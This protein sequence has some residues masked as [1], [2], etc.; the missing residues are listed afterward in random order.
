MAR[1]E[2]AIRHALVA[3]GYLAKTE[4]GNLKHAHARLTHQDNIFNMYYGKAVGA[5]IESMEDKSCPIEVG[6]AACL[7]FVCIEFMRGNFIVAFTHLQSGLKIIS[8]LPY[9]LSSG[10]LPRSMR[11]LPK[12]PRSPT[13]KQIKFAGS[14]G[15]LDDTLIP[16]FMRNITPAMLFGTRVEEIF[17]IPI[18]D[19]QSY[20]FPFSTFYELQR[21]SFQLRNASA[22][23]ARTMA[24]KIFIKV[25]LRPEDFQARSQLLDAHQSWL[26]A[27]ERL[28]QAKCLSGE[29]IVMAASLK[30]GYYSTYILI[31]CAMDLRQC[32]FDAHL[33]YFKA[34][35]HNARIVLESMDLPIVLPP[36]SGGRQSSSKRLSGTLSR[37]STSTRTRPPGRVSLSTMRSIHA[38]ISGAHF[39]FE[40]SVIP[41]LHFV[42]TRCRC[43]TTRR[44]AVALLETNP[45]REGL[46]DVETHIAVAKRV[47]EIEETTLDPET[48]W[49]TEASRLWCSVHDGKGYSDGKILVTFAFAQW[50]QERSPRPDD[51]R[52]VNGADRS[53]AQW[54]ELM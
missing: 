45:P 4:P 6:L 19:P 42:A 23:F 25:P 3:L 11:I 39:T 17:E 16:M 47:I 22:L 14:S 37:S 9:R 24:T 30:L 8:E 48:G 36:A 1:S 31:H 50:A 29:E 2:P 13:A 51:L 49:P 7:L 38:K 20:D 53:D 33:D 54:Q 46:W 35:N 5:L 28:E 43:P 18:P 52:P 44:E 27:L 15:L 41:P 10:L 26:K 32:N 21:A 12:S 40:I 34:I